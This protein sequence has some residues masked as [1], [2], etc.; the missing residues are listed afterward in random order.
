MPDH[1]RLHCPG[2]RFGRT[3]A[4]LLRWNWGTD[5]SP[6]DGEALASVPPYSLAERAASRVQSP[7]E[8]T[9]FKDSGRHGGLLRDFGAENSGN[10]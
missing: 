1:Q 3:A 2:P 9:Q 4:A 7:R 8:Q 6:P 10:Q 5:S